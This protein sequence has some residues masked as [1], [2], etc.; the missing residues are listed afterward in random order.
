MDL[1]YYKNF[2]DA[3]MLTIFIVNKI[4]YVAEIRFDLS[5]ADK[6][7]FEC[8]KTE[9]I[10]DNSIEDGWKGIKPF[11]TGKATVKKILDS[12]EKVIKAGY[13]NYDTGEFFMQI[14]YSNASCKDNAV[15]PGKFNV[16][17]NTVLNYDLVFNIKAIVLSDFKFQREKYRRE[18]DSKNS[19]FA[20]YINDDDGIKLYV[21]V[22]KGA[23][24]VGRVEF[25]VSEKDKKKFECKN[26]EP[27]IVKPI[28]EE[29]KSNKAVKSVSKIKFSSAYTK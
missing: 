24:Y 1:V 13:T 28:A 14:T 3:V 22:F 18:T 25:F 19:E 6:R 17:E 4:K 2:D 21:R 29:S 16:P 11:R 10:I 5:P 8:K 23:E 27:V 15:K 9:E 20:Y 12:A 26:S 7:K